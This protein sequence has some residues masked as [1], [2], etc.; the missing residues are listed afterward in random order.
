MVRRS[1]RQMFRLKGGSHLEVDDRDGYLLIAA[2]G[3]LA[4][5]DDAAECASTFERVMQERGTRRALLDVRMQTDEPSP[6]VRVA[7]W[8]WFKSEKSFDLCAY[9]VPEASSMKAARVNM[10]AISFGMNLRAFVSVVEAHRFLVPRRTSTLI[11]AQRPS[12][13]IPPVASSDATARSTKQKP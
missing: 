11:P 4:D 6:D 8:D 5:L 9:L 1:G 13:T 3:V 10:T 12:S 2:S 7:V